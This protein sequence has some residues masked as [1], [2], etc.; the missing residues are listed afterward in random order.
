MSAG[1]DA[2]RGVDR[3]LD[4]AVVPGYTR[5]G[6]ALR[7]RRWAED[8]PAPDALVGQHALVTGAGRGLGE[9]TALGLARLG[10]TVHLVVRSA[11]RATS[12]VERITGALAMEG[13]QAD[14]RVEECDVSDLGAVRQF[15]TEVVGRLESSGEA[16]DVLVHNA[17]VMP[18]ART[19]SVDGHELTMATHVLGPVLLTELLRPALRRSTTGAR[20]I[21]ISSGGQYTQRL[22]VDDLEFTRDRYRGSVAYARSKRAQVELTPRLAERWA[23]DTA[24]YAMH[25][26][27]ADTP[28]VA[29]S[30]PGFHRLTGPLLRSAAEGA[31]T[32]VWLAGT[33][34]EPPTGTFWH[35]REQ[36][37]I[38]YLRRTKSAPADL[39][40][41]EQW[42]M[43]AVGLR[44]DREAR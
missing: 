32:V 8:D 15:A 40:D 3:L 34:P 31:D 2:D 43:D 20:T 13:R 25:P 27:W 4:R 37:P 44:G 33:L 5:L 36:R 6:F 7:R 19:A 29:S 30:L 12:A 1:S 26:G 23:G 11:D 22:R 35:D 10:A 16:L 21:L 41:L 18:E 17:G 9:A 42:V 39:R 28:G 38:D 14:L 24:V